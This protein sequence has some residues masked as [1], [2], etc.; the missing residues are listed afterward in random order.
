M[1]IT[2]CEFFG[3]LT[4]CS[5][6]SATAPNP[7]PRRPASTQSSHSSP[8][9]KGHLHVNAATGGQ[10][11][12]TRITATNRKVLHPAQLLCN[13]S[14]LAH[15]IPQICMANWKQGRWLLKKGGFEMNKEQGV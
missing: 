11:Q 2:M 1:Q 3:R 8:S 7:P 5:L 14:I 4:P 10:Q 13:W 6:P 12:I 9:I 15:V